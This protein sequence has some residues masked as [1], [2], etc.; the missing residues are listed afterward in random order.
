MT[1]NVK[2]LEHMF[3]K[4]SNFCNLTVSIL[5]YT[6]M[7]YTFREFMS[8]CKYM[9]I[10]F[11]NLI[12][13]QQ[14]EETPLHYAAMSGNTEVVNA[15]LKAGSKVDEKDQVSMNLQFIEEV[16]LPHAYS[17]KYH[18]SHNG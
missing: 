9:Y 4:Y 6:W 8:V 17:C 14:M 15:L 16:A 13:T 5:Q 12:F 1:R 18:D 10:H 11:V 7:G 3:F 2:D